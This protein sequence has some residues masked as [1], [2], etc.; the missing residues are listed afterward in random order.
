[1][2][3]LFRMTGGISISEDPALRFTYRDVGASA[4]QVT[5]RDTDGGLY[6]KSFEL[7]TGS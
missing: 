5:S 1:D 2:T 6:R 3:E 7:Q 4:M